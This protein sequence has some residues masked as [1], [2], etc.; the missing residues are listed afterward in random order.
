MIKEGLWW[1]EVEEASD[2]RMKLL[3]AKFN[4]SGLYINQ[5]TFERI[6][7]VMCSD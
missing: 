7:L 4:E 1:Y 3:M 2:G 6:I 5:Y